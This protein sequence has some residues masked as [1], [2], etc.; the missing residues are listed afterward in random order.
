MFAL[1]VELPLSST[2]FFAHESAV[3]GGMLPGFFSI[4]GVEGS[5][6]VGERAAGIAPV[7]AGAKA[8][9][10]ELVCSSLCKTLRANHG[11]VIDESVI[12]FVWGLVL[13]GGLF[14]GKACL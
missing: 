8:C 7:F 12:V 11:G 13:V 14:V 6:R 9:V 3:D 10:G 5:A 1:C 2:Q 4:G